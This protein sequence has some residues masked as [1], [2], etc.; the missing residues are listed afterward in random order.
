MFNLHNKSGRCSICKREETT[1]HAE[2]MPGY[3]LYVC[4]HCLTLAKTHFI[5]ICMSCGNSY[6]R[7]K[8]EVLNRLTDPELKRAY[9]QC[10]QM[11]LI[12]GID[13]CIACDPEG[14]V[15]FVDSAKLEKVTGRC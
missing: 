4:D 10:E 15:E 7:S 14:I 3:D 5:W 9:E 11:Q 12:Q 6:S 1:I 13:M 8:E 2:A